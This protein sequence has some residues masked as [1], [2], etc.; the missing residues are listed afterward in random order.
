MI[1]HTNA[2]DV[3]RVVRAA[4]PLL[5]EKRVDLQRAWSETGYLI[6]SLRDNPVTAK[7]EYDRILDL[8]DPG[9]NAKLTFDPAENIAAP[10][11]A[12][13]FSEPIYESLLRVSA[14][15]FVIRPLANISNSRDKC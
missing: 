11:I 15:S 5:A 4:K 8:K 10:F 9:L 2:T 7:Q 1:G 3:L 12:K 6:Q 14:I 13:W